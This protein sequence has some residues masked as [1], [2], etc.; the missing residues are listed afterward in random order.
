MMVPLGA[1]LDTCEMLN[2]LSTGGL[3]EV[4]GTRISP[5]K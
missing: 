4:R 2:P 3:G 1:Q 5:N